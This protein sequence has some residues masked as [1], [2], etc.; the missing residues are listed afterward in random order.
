MECNHCCIANL[1]F[2]SQ[3][4]NWRHQEK[5]SNALNRF[6][7]YHLACMS[8]VRTACLVA[9]AEVDGGVQMHSLYSHLGAGFL[10]PIY[11]GGFDWLTIKHLHTSLWTCN[12]FLCPQ[13]GGGT[14]SF[15]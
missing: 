13:T 14:R 8:V 1:K 15:P 10:F 2:S 6:N 4:H 11:S 12:V 7:L 9:M 3:I 5:S